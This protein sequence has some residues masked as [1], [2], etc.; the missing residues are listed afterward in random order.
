MQ[1]TVCQ[2]QK[3]NYAEI[4]EHCCCVSDKLVIIAAIAGVFAVLIFLIGLICFRR[5]GNYTYCQ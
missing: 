2:Q 4:Y 5:F 3:Y 1:T